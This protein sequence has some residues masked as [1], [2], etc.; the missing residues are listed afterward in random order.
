MTGIPEVG[1]QHTIQTLVEWPGRE[2]AAPVVVTPA[3][4]EWKKR[5]GRK[6]KERGKGERERK[7]RR[8]SLK[9]SGS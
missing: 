4:K 5:V 3:G 8:K 2:V 7:R 1:F 9:N 6:R